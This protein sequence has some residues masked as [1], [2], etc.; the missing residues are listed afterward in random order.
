MTALPGYGLETRDKKDVTQNKGIRGGKHKEGLE[1]GKGGWD[2]KGRSKWRTEVRKE[3]WRERT[4]QW[5][6]RGGREA[7]RREVYPHEMILRYKKLV[8]V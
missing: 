1:R 6:I 7:G 5:C 2:G 3:R 8:C 4:R